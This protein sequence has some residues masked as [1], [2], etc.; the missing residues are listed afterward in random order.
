MRIIAG[1]R[2]GRTLF[3]PQGRNTRPTL[4]RVKEALFGILQLETP[5]AAV[6]DLFAG[7]GNLGLEALSRG[8]SH[9]LFCDRD[10][11][12][13]AAIRRNIE[14]LGFEAQ[15]R[16]IAGDFM[17]ALR[18][19][20]REGLRFDLVF[21]DPPYATDLAQK[22]LGVLSEVEL[23]TQDAVL[24]VEHDP[25]APPRTPGFTADTRR[26]GDVG[27]SILRREGAH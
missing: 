16:V 27:L 21:L 18:Q 14:A 26:Y 15:S 10:P 8:A 20:Q 1:S 2:K 13:L 17:A 12:S 9:A 4:D 23:L 5:G 19:A 22:A 6:L 24:V 7:S 11:K 3:A 25:A